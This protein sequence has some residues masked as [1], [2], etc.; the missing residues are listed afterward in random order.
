MG[1]PGN[2]GDID[3]NALP[4]LSHD[5]THSLSSVERS[6]QIHVDG[7]LP[8]PGIQIQQWGMRFHSGV[9]D[10]DVDPLPFVEDLCHHSLDGHFLADIGDIIFYDPPGVADLLNSMVKI[11]RGDIIGRDPRSLSPKRSCDLPADTPTR[12]SDKDNFIFKVHSYS[13]QSWLVYLGW[14]S[15]LLVKGQ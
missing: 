11:D 13:L 10:Q 12:A 5:A 14:L 4:L 9:V 1:A 15:Q 2:G 3:N 7:T 8:I 6:T